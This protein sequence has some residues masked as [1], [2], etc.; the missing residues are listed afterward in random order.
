MERAPSTT[1]RRPP[2]SEPL[3][4][5]AR[6]STGV[7]REPGGCITA[8]GDDSS[9]RVRAAADARTD[10]VRPND[11]P[12]GRSTHLTQFSVSA[13]EPGTQTTGTE[14]AHYHDRGG[15]SPDGGDCHSAPAGHRR[16]RARWWQRSNGRVARTDRAG[17]LR[18][19]FNAGRSTEYAAGARATYV[20]FVRATRW[21]FRCGCV[22]IIAS[23]RPVRRKPTIPPALS[24]ISTRC[25][26]V[27][28][29]D[30]RAELLADIVAGQLVQRGVQV[31]RDRQDVRHPLLAAASGAG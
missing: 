12:A 21:M 15:S 4:L 27:L 26:D 5:Q 28:R 6:D 8:T 30:E 14:P 11:H 19:W 25:D 1:A 16:R 23:T 10:V 22:R 7:A 9:H 29:T 2:P 13:G 24:A 3:P 20:S 17:T 31:H 18:G